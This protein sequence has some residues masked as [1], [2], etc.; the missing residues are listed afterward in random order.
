MSQYLRPVEESQVLYQG[1][2]VDKK[3]FRAFVYNSNC[4]KLANSYDE[5]AS[6]I[7]SGLWF[8]TKEDVKPVEEVKPEK[9]INIKDRKRKHG[10]D[11]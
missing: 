3:N 9:P 1:R 5:Y 8:S 4:E 6:L 10:T 7:E 2:W 11:S